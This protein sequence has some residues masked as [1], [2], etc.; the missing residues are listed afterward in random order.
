[1]QN[2]FHSHFQYKSNIFNLIQVFLQIL[3][4]IKSQDI[5]IV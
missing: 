5:V 3:T 2:L 1:M 4:L